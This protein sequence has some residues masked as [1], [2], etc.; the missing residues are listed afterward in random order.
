MNEI[1]NMDQLTEELRKLGLDANYYMSGGGCG[2]IYIGKAD[3]EGFFSFGVGPSS[4]YEGTA[5]IAGLSWGADDKSGEAPFFT[6]EDH[7][8]TES[9]WQ[10]ISVQ[11][12]AQFI[13]HDYKEEM[14]N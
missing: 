6:V 10:F 2:T 8:F 9:L 5:H 13:L 1:I 4:Y 11:G 12:L 3:E 14:G 7:I